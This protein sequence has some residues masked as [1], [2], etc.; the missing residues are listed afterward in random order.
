M[1]VPSA[2][3]QPNGAPDRRYDGPRQGAD[4]SPQRFVATPVDVLVQGPG[5]GRSGAHSVVILPTRTC[6][7]PRVPTHASPR[8]SA[9]SSASRARE[10]LATVENEARTSATPVGRAAQKAYAAERWAELRD[11]LASTTPQDLGR[12]ALATVVVGGTVAIGVAT[13]PT[14]LPFVGGGL[15]AYLLLPVVDLHRSGHATSPR[16]RWRYSRCWR[17]SAQSR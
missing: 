14:L 7:G 11:R 6:G 8:A 15:I 13:W 9:P 2:S 1:T 12:A 5:N 3:A 10:M 17:G 16:P 4:Q